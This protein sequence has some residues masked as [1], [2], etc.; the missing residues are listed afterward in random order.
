M[1]QLSIVVAF[2]M[3]FLSGCTGPASTDEKQSEGAPAGVCNISNYKSYVFD[4]E[5]YRQLVSETGQGCDLRGADLSGENFEDAVLWQADLSG[6]KLIEV[7][8]EDAILRGTNMQ[9]ADAYKANFDGAEMTSVDARGAKFQGADLDAN[10]TNAKLQ[11]AEYDDDTSFSFGMW[12]SDTA[13]ADRGMI[14]K[15][16]N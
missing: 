12:W 3:G 11:G 1:F 16:Y 10:L 2:L 9:G 13:V 5:K 8:F 4:Q 14:K 6:A 7:D 15:P